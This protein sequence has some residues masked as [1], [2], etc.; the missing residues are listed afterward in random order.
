LAPIHCAPILRADPLPPSRADFTSFRNPSAADSS[1]F[2]VDPLCADSSTCG[3]DSSSP[4]CADFD[5]LLIL[6]P[7]LPIDYPSCG[8]DSSF[9][10]WSI[11][12]G[13]HRALIFHLLDFTFFMFSAVRLPPV[14]LLIHRSERNR[15]NAQKEK[16]DIG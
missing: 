9:G 5:L 12:F 11:R 3:A 8:A 2:G 4:S 10:N 16:I 14:H 13:V 1:S 7:S 15:W 6:H